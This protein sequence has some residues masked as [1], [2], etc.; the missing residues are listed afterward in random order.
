MDK[1]SRVLIG[2][3][4]QIP[5][6]IALDVKYQSTYFPR[7]HL[8][9]MVFSPS[10]AQ[11]STWTMLWRCFLAESFR[12]TKRSHSFDNFTYCR[13]AIFF[14]LSAGVVSFN[15]CFAYTLDCGIFLKQTPDLQVVGHLCSAHL[16]EVYQTTR[17]E[18][19]SVTYYQ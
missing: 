14:L 9:P 5:Q 4:L 3:W 8:A 11:T 16:M 18:E 6:V 10:P 1:W 12:A 2:T 17:K 19:S 13:D 15:F 7:C